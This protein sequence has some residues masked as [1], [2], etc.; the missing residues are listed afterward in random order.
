MSEFDKEA[1]RNQ[2]IRTMLARGK[3]DRYFNPTIGVRQLPDGVKYVKDP[4]GQIMVLKNELGKSDLA[5]RKI[6]KKIITR[7]TDL[8]KKV[9]AAN[10]KIGEYSAGGFNT[11]PD[12]AGEETTTQVEIQRSVAEQTDDEYALMVN[13]M[14][15]NGGVP[16]SFTKDK[17]FSRTG[18]LVDTSFFG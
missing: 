1:E 18:A 11:G 6:E 2:Q 14:K 17:I 3:N 13:Y 16:A 8:Q 15:A 9:D 12:V 10:S 4:D 5:L 7:R